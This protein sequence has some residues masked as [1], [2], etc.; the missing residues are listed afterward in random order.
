MEMVVLVAAT[1][2]QP[3]HV[4]PTTLQ[5]GAHFVEARADSG[6]VDD[7]AVGSIGDA[8]EPNE[9]FQDIR[10]RQDADEF[11]AVDD[12]QG[13][14]LGAA[15]FVGCFVDGLPWADGDGVAG[16]DGFDAFVLG[17]GRAQVA[18]G[19]DTDEEAFVDDRK[20]TYAVAFEHAAGVGD[21]FLGSDGHDTSGH[22]VANQHGT[23]PRAGD[24][25]LP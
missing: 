8:G 19:D 12:G 4:G 15:H 14:D 6:G 9:G 5:D 18:I 10:G 21:G 25:R 16:H 13:I 7:H 1:A 3:E 11:F 20:L 2:A 22:V 17:C 23:P 24:G